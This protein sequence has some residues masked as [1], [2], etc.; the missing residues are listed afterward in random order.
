MD[1]PSRVHFF[2]TKASRSLYDMELRKGDW[3][4]FGCETRGLGPEVIERHRE[5][6]VKIPFP[7]PIRSFNLANTVSMALCEG[8][9]QLQCH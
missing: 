3:L 2:S 5:Q 9:R 1:D 7:G 4:V 8:L 6:L